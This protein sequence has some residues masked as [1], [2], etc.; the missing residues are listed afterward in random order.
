MLSL[1]KENRHVTTTSSLP[2]V[3]EALVSAR[4]TS[5]QDHYDATQVVWRALKL[6]LE[7]SSWAEVCA[8]A[9]WH[10]QQM[11]ERTA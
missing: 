8:A 9:D 2:N 5:V 4:G 6:R 11:A 1:A 10:A 3:R 7:G